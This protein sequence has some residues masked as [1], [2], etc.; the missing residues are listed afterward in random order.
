MKPLQLPDPPLTDGAVTLRGWRES[1]VQD[2][3]EA[4]QDPE[5]PRWTIRIPWPYLIG[6]ARDWV[7]RQPDFLRAREAAQFAI[8]D[9]DSGRL[10]GGIGLELHP[11]GGQPEI[12]YWL[13]RDARGRGAAT[14]A[15]RLVAGWGLDALGLELIGLRTHAEN[16]ASQA[17]AVRAGFVP[18]GTIGGLDRH[19]IAREFLLFTRSAARGAAASARR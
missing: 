16:L 19:G 1:D 10:L 15:T 11:D 17:V 8:T 2:L 13:A 6:H 5:I 7:A 12:G 9:A 14:R 3:F 4:C 18:A